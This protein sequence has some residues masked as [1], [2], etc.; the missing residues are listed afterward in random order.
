[1]TTQ[2]KI[3]SAL[4][5]RLEGFSEEQIRQFGAICAAAIDSYSNENGLKAEDV[6]DNVG[7]KAVRWA[8]VNARD[9]DS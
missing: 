9:I 5:K 2:E 4:S 3:A 8:L 7:K 1:M 6:M